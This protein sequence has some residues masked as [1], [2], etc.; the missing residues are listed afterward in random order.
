MNIKLKFV[1]WLCPETSNLPILLKRVNNLKTQIV[2]LTNKLRRSENHTKRLNDLI[3]SKNTECTQAQRIYVTDHAIHQYKAR[4]P[5]EAKKNLGS[6][7]DI[8]K[9]IYNMVIKHL[10]TLDKLSDGA[11]DIDKNM[12]CRIKDN[13]VVTCLPRRGYKS[14]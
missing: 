8:R 12:V 7:E 11:Y 6:N 1:N 9:K 13:T 4:V 10:H 14:K 2:I 3:T 5:K